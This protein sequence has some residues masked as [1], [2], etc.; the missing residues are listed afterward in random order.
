M[1]SSVQALMQST[2]VRAALA[3]LHG[4]AAGSSSPVTQELVNLS[5]RLLAQMGPANF[6]PFFDAA[7]A[8][9]P[10]WSSGQ[11]D[12]GEFLSKLVTAVPQ[13]E[14]LC[15]QPL[16]LPP[17]CAECQGEL[18]EVDKPDPAWLPAVV[19]LLL[20]ESTP[21]STS[22]AAHSSAPNTSKAGKTSSLPSLQTLLHEHLRPASVNVKCNLCYR[23]QL[24][25]HP[26]K[27]SLLRGGRQTP[28][29][30]VCLD[31]ALPTNNQ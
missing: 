19:V 25:E 21:L 31:R 11:H 5:R 6:E 20:P 30:L 9:D 12:A 23:P 28:L 16:P 14:Q 2:A 24:V 7:C 18:H 22:K 3:T 8:L 1:I 29:M 26:V 4:T 13:L 15:A 17:R 27:L 10:M